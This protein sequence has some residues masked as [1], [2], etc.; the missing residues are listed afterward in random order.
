[1]ILRNGKFYLDMPDGTQPLAGSDHF[2]AAPAS[3][4]A[5]KEDLSQPGGWK[6]GIEKKE[7]KLSN[8]TWR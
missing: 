2:S 7:M 8:I 3:L 1:M 4:P 5:S 6:I